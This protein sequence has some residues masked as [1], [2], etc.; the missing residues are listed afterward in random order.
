MAI[1][2]M[3]CGVSTLSATTHVLPD[4]DSQPEPILAEEVSTPYVIP[5]KTALML[6]FV[7]ETSSKTAVSGNKVDFLLAEDLVIDGTVVLK[8]GNKA[9]GEV[10]HAQKSGFGGRGGELIIGVRSLDVDGQVIPL[11]SLKPIRGQYIG[12]NNSDT[13]FAV[14]L[15]P[16]AGLASLFITGGEIVLPAGTRAIAL[17]ASDTAVV[18]KN[19]VH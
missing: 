7:S 19:V 17:V 6:E 5:A 18:V 4:L 13:A 9:F 11:R 16:Y 1:M 15:I 3:A 10:I 14:S 8:K 2:L 12:Q